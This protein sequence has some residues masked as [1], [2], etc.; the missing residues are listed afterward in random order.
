MNQQFFTSY[1]IFLCLDL[2]DLFYEFL[3]GVKYKNRFDGFFPH[4]SC[5]EI[6][7]WARSGYFTYIYSFYLTYIL[8]LFVMNYVSYL[9][10]YLYI[11]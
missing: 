9:I 10:D 3:K 1:S 5:V 11:N 4:T 6:S 7:R 8:N 2:F